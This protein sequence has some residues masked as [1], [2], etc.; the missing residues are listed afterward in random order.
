LNLNLLEVSLKGAEV[1]QKKERLKALECR[2]N[3]LLKGG[4][5]GGLEG[6]SSASSIT[7]NDK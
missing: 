4:L 1:E 3:I 2:G 7:K 6:A 5:G